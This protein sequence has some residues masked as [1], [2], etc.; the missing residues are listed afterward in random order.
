MKKTLSMILALLML[1]SAL[2]A[3]GDTE[4]GET[5]AQI[6]TNAPVT[7]TSVTDAPENDAPVVYPYDTSLVTENGVAKAHIVLA[8]EADQTLTFAAQELV[9]HVQTVSG[10]ALS[11]TNAA[12]EDSLP[13]IIATPES[14]PELE[15]LFADDLAW[16]RTLGEVGDTERWGDDGFAIRTLD[17]KIYIFGATARGALNG[18]Y[19]FI[20]ENL[21][22]I[23]IRADM[24]KGLV[25]DEMPTITAVKA[26]YREKS[27]FQVRGI[28]RYGASSDPASMDLLYS[29]NKYNCGAAHAGVWVDAMTRESTVGLEPM[30]S[31]HNA[32]WWL[33]VSPIYDPNV[34]EYWETLPDGTPMDIHSSRQLNYWSEL[35]ADTVAASVIHQL[36]LYHDSL[37]LRH[38]G[39]CI[40]DLGFVNGVS[41]AQNEPFEYA[42]GQFVN[43]DDEDYQSTVLFSFIN[44]VARQVA[45]KYPDA[46]VNTYAY[47]FASI[48]PRCD[49]ED[50]VIAVFCHYCEDLTQRTNDIIFPGSTSE[51]N[52]NE[53]SA[54]MDKTTNVINY[55]YYGC[56]FTGGWYERA[57]WYRM[58]NDMQL[59]AEHGMVGLTPAIYNDDE[60]PFTLLNVDWGFTYGD[61]WE[62]NILTHWLYAKLAWNPYEDVDALIAEFCDKVYGDAAEHMQEYYRL[63]SVSWEHGAVALI[64]DFQPVYMFRNYPIDYYN[65]FIDIDAD[66]VHLLEAIQETLDKAWEAADDKAKEYIR[67]PRE[68]FADPESHLAYERLS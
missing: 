63:L 46:L 29:R 7:D 55:N 1:A 16:L 22:V 41:P 18:V 43:P 45:E 66:G 32:K 52:Y 15:T 23:W 50:N 59:Y 14:M 61:I 40:E 19:D 11:V 2:V 9:Y 49:L 24:S 60:N 17:G 3:C 6:Q 68:C 42:P 36:D 56:Y 4:P 64:D 37:G 30:V 39:V 44:R 8:A 12:G 38:V 53:F 25:Y 58:Q 57:I 26:D 20:E 27:P 13:I 21:G 51:R 34:T 62:M 67:H 28:S 47:T 5:T 31:N 65:Y 35:T 48:P 54:W 33:Q 10:A